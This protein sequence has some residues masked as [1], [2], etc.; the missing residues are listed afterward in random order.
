MS[1]KQASSWTAAAMALVL[2][3]VSWPAHAETFD[4]YVAACKA[5]LG[6]D[7]IPRFPCNEHQFRFR[8]NGIH[9]GLLF[10][11]SDDFVAH[12]QIN[13]SVDAVFACRWTARSRSNRAV[14]GEMIVH[15]RRTGGTCFFELKDTFEDG[16]YPQV[17]IN[18]VSP[19]SSGASASWTTSTVC[20]ACHVAG[21]YIASPQIAP[22]LAKF[23]LMNDGHDTFN[24]KYHA[25]G[26]SNSTIA[27]KLNAHLKNVSKPA[28]ASACH[29]VRSGPEVASFIGAG[30]NFASVRMPSINHV[31]DDIL[32]KNQMP[33][34][35]N[36]DYRWLNR[37]DPGATGD[38]ETISELEKDRTSGK[39]DL[40]RLYCSSPRYTEAR[41]VGSEGTFTSST[42]AKFRVFNLHDGVV[43]KV[44]DQPKNHPYPCLDLQTRYLCDGQWT[45]WRGHARTADGDDES[46]ARYKKSFGLCANPT[47]L[48]VR[49]MQ[50]IAGAPYGDP[51]FAPRDRLAQFDN[52]GLICKHADQ[53]SGKRCGNYTVRFT[54]N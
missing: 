28:C 12:R 29:V 8:F 36:S 7:E 14:G 19:T 39:Q 48:Q 50:P 26:A 22:A 25:V 51:F 49:Q 16:A 18:P 13:N 24:K 4:Q 53:P 41:R 32:F 23:G 2:G 27:P 47:D 31:I 52:K 5:Q 54:C 35:A 43:C 6:F 3:V 15:N 38:N 37:D 46:R 11:E 1:N 42:F 45:P 9:L 40:S 44:A 30:L 33:P 10:D 21:P 17:P 34:T 20:T